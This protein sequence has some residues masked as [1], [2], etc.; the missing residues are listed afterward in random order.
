[1]GRGRAVGVSTSYGLVDLVGRALVG[2]R[3]SALVQRGPE[4][5]PPSCTKD[6][7]AL[8]WR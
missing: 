5:Y 1:M 2:A 6:N 3:F 7:V 8:C 4:A